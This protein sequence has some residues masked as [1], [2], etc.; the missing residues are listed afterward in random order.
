MKDG[1]ESSPKTPSAPL[2]LNP[3]F[4]EW[5]MGWRMQWTSPEPHACGAEETA[6]W[7]SALRSQ[8]SN[9]FGDPAS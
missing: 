4:V 3:I 2:R 5:L 6:L 7:R 9:F 8:L 1:Q